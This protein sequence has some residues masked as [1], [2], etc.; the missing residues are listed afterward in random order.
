MKNIMIS[1][2]KHLDLRSKPDGAFFVRLLFVVGTIFGCAFGFYFCDKTSFSD[3]TIFSVQSAAF[4]SLGDA[5]WHTF[6]FPVSALL[7]GTSFIGIF[8][9]PALSLVYAY[10]LSLSVAA[11]YFTAGDNVAAYLLVYF[12]VPSLFSLPCFFTLSDS[13]FSS[14]RR[15]YFFRFH[16]MVTGGRTTPYTKILLIFFI[17]FLI[18]LY[19]FYVAPDLLTH[20]TN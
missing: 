18:S 6:K 12:V 8:L 19:S 7:F 1:T 3:T 14:A 11:V 13:M 16:E 17:L 4:V 15:L 2:I 20:I 5:V 10:L 9:I